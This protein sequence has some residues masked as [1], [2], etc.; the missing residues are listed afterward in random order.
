MKR[1]KEKKTKTNKNKNKKET[2]RATL[3]EAVRGGQQ[4]NPQRCERQK[5]KSQAG[6]RAWLLMF[7]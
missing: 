7:G 6:S 5:D 2:K 3:N 4:I 1:Q